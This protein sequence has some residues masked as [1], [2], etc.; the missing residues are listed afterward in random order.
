MICKGCPHKYERSEPFL[1]LSI[2]VK[3]QKSVQQSLNAFIQGEMLEGDN[4]YFCEKCD[5]KVDTLK[6][7][8]IKK[9][10]KNLIVA[11]RRFEFDYDRMVRVK[12]ND[13]CEFPVELS[14]EPYTQEGLS[15][16]ERIQKLKDEKGE[17]E[18]QAAIEEIENEPLKYPKEYYEYQL[19]GIVVHS[20]TADSGH[21]YSFIK[22]RDHPEGNKWYEMNDHIVRDF[23]PNDI[24]TECYGGEDIF[25]GYN[26]VQMKT[27][28]WRNA[29]LLF[30]ERKVPEDIVSEEEASEKVNTATVEI[31]ADDIE[32]QMVKATSSAPQVVIP[33]EIE[34]KI[35][36]ENQ[37]YW[38][39]RFL[40]GNEYHDFVYDISQNWNTNNIIPKNYLT[41]NDDFHLNGQICPPEY[42][43][44]VNIADPLDAKMPMDEG[45]V[46]EFEFRVFKFAAR[47]YLTILQRA[48][49]KTHIPNMLNLLKAY[50]NKN[51]QSAYWLIQEFCNNEILEE[52]LLQCSSKEMRKFTVGLLYCSMLKVYPL[53]R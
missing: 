44:D 17:D 1:S 45:A 29:Y 4:A 19:S 16:R 8:C 15:R 6:R 10:P 37:K 11:M 50:I 14:L 23:D 18:A 34:S 26:G 32:M 24:P 12:V 36:Y 41:K 40:F 42:M 38:Q 31:P 2:S 39:N 53:E 20:G 30:Y 3:N 25:T 48:Q 21:Y 52:M 35:L 46:A 33:S 43:N 22:D 51:E 5:K 28:K 27:M 49:L 7:T 13:Y 47:F 9:F